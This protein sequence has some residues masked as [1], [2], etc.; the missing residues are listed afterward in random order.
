LAVGQLAKRKEE[1]KRKRKEEK[2]KRREKEKKKR[3][4]QRI[5]SFFTSYQLFPAL[6]L[7]GTESNCLQPMQTA[8]YS[9]T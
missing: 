4:M 7:P 1:K 8:L 5:G 3:K 6:V 2:K 9:F